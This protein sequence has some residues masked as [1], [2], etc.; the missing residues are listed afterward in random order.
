M[1]NSTEPKLKMLVAADEVEK[2]KASP[3]EL[4]AVLPVKQEWYWETLSWSL[5]FPD[6]YFQVLMHLLEQ[7]EGPWQ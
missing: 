4:K 6:K 7:E 1:E 2:G 5:D 3:W